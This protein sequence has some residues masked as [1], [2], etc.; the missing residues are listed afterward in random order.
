MLS[1]FDLN[2]RVA[3]GYTD[4]S[5]SFVKIAAD[6]LRTAVDAQYAN[7]R[8]TPDPLISINPS[9][10][11]GK[12]IGTEQFPELHEHTASV[13]SID[14]KPIR[15]HSHQE[16]ALAY[17]LR[18]ESYVV[19]TGT[20]SGK[21]L[22]FFV[23]I[24]DAA[25][26]A[27]KSG[28][29]NTKAIIIY[30]MNALAN[31]QLK[32]IEK[33]LS[34]SGLDRHPTVG[35]YTG[36][37]SVEEKQAIADSPPDILLTN[38]VMLELLLTRGDERDRKVIENCH[39]LEWLVLDEL[40]TY[41]GR[42]GADVAMLV[43]RL[44]EQLEDSRPMTCIGT[45][46]TMASGGDLD[47][48][49]TEIVS[50][51]ATKIF[52]TDVPPVRVIEEDLRRVTHVQWTPTSL[53]D[54]MRAC[55]FAVPDE[56]L[57]RNPLAAWVELEVGLQ[58]E[59]KRRRRAPRTVE[60]VV[61][62][63]ARDSGEP[64]DV[65]R[66]ALLELLTQATRSDRDRGG[67][68]DTAFLAFKLHRFLSGP[69]D[70][71]ATLGRPGE[72]RVVFDKQL[73]E[74]ETG[75]PLYQTRFCR[76][77]GQEY[78]P[79]RH[80]GGAF[81][82]RDIDDVPVDKDEDPTGFL[83]LDSAGLAFGGAVEDYPDSWLD[84]AADGEVTLRKNRKKRRPVRVSV[85]PDGTTGSADAVGAWFVPG[86]FAFCLGCLDTPAPQGRDRSRL[87]GL[88]AEGRSSATTV[89]TS[90][91]LLAMS[92][93]D[94][95][96]PER[97]RKLLAFTDN[98][99]D[100]ALQAGHFNDTMFVSR[101]RAGFLAAL[102]GA[103]DEGL[104]D[105]GLG[106]AVRRALGFVE[107]ERDRR[108]EWMAEPD[109]KGMAPRDAER[110]L[111]E[112]LGHRVWADQR[113][114][115]RFSFPNL[116]ELGLLRVEYPMVDECAADDEVWVDAPDRVRSAP[117]DRRARALDHV[118]TTMRQG[119][120]VA[121]ESLSMDRLFELAKTS[122][123]R[124]VPPW[125]FADQEDLRAAPYL[126]T[127]PVPKRRIRARDERLLLRGGAQ[128][129]LGKTL[130]ARGLWDEDVPRKDY[131]ELVGSLLEAA[132]IYGLVQRESTPFDFP[133][134]RL[135]A[136]AVRFHAGDDTITPARDNPY[137]RDLYLSLAEALEREG[138]VLDGLEAREH[139]AQVTPAMREHRERRF[140]Y[141]DADREMMAAAAHAGDD[142]ESFRRLPLMFCSP[143]M[144]LGVDI[145][146]LDV[147]Y[148]RNVP[149]TPA[150]YTQRA[151]RAGRAGQPAL[152]T[153]YCAAQSPHDQYYFRSR[154]Q[155]VAGEVRPPML[156][157]ANE[158]LVRSHLRAVWLAE[159]N[160]HLASDIAAVVDVALDGM[161]LRP[162]VS[163]P[164][165]EPSL[166]GRAERRMLAVLEQRF[167]GEDDT[168]RLVRLAREE[169]A[170]AF[171]NF[172]EA[173]RSWR[174]R[175]EAA[176]AQRD[177]A[178]EI[179][180]RPD[181]SQPEKKQA[182][183]AYFSANAQIDLLEGGRGGNTD[184]FTYR[185]LATEGFLPGYD[186]PRLPLTA[187]VP[188]GY[189]GNGRGGSYLSRSRFL[190]LAEFGPYSL[191]YHEGQA[192]RVVKAL[193]PPGTQEGD[194]LRTTTLLICAACG[195]SQK[196]VDNERCELCAAS[197]DAPIKIERAFRIENVETSPAERISA[198]D[199]ERQRQ[200]F[201][202]QTTFRWED[203]SVVEH[204]ETRA[205]GDTVATLA[206]SP[207]A[208]IVRIN[209]GLRRRRNPSVMGFGIGVRS[210]RWA[211]EPDDEDDAPANPLDEPVVRIVP[212][213]EDRKN[214]L[215][216]SLGDG[217]VLDESDVAT[218]QSAL[219]RGMERRFQLEE[220][221]IAIEP[222]PDRTERRN[223]LIYEASEGGAG[224]LRRLVGER[225]AL[226]ALAREALGAMHLSE[227]DGGWVDE[228]S[229]PCVRGCYRCLLS[230]Y[231]QPDH[232]LID[233]RSER[234]RDFLER[235]ARAEVVDT[236][237]VDTE[238]GGI[239][240]APKSEA[241]L[242]Q[243]SAT[244]VAATDDVNGDSEARTAWAAAARRWGLPAPDTRA[245][246]TAVGEALLGWKSLTFAITDDDAVLDALAAKGYEVVLVEREPPE[247]MPAS[248][249]T[250]FG[251]A[252]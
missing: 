152:I 18:R 95:G 60:E 207:A 19:T 219:A 54:S 7:G 176:R 31:S 155:M 48:R 30:P 157:L 237:S 247:T 64:E 102:R 65:C 167:A 73:V 178:A 36:Q 202:L 56:A 11:G 33:F 90:G 38:F 206:Y 197:L 86:R 113:R 147:V 51:V 200:G 32:E 138:R 181:V 188:G 80:D 170:D 174:D 149:P 25:L 186:F 120:A 217:P 84:A 243:T 135:T 107:A 145:S 6:D 70:L 198:N 236:G 233:R 129:R 131:A 126:L 82:F 194:G 94:S 221:E 76:A 10:E 160:I 172:E 164:L 109:S 40:H 115:W 108:V 251:D 245:P 137:Y 246:R 175:L 53:A 216:L 123:G 110:T 121:T 17:G 177:L 223:L 55:D 211:K 8:Y 209:K 81:A 12:T 52:A 153:T 156:D 191:V 98:R 190:A 47:G 119:L 125:S 132:R 187:F 50:G 199:E 173:F 3:R 21:S 154:D 111:T 118:L 63:L 234:A 104:G 105:E 215:L 230:Y 168:K 49:S 39:G 163:E 165:S 182:D 45:S 189:R 148:L 192:N 14:G 195:S 100:A 213:V 91:M 166:A 83:C 169:A 29:K 46:A 249:G 57:E 103:G 224:V 150:N 205:D 35:R 77:C 72:R 252:A 88:S 214:A 161:P 58:D 114:G 212:I 225:G 116:E 133:G 142:V 78:H 127:E 101:L 238:D 5:R 97:K 231:N 27:N 240:A 241:A 226:A 59:E 185:Y 159:A 71:Y 43:S 228:E 68:R 92:R 15:L 196:A 61:T 66:E 130:S 151:G 89:V 140:R 28:A 144:E 34:Q 117:A 128:S 106:Q 1:V 22:C 75:A 96:V 9:F 139:T 13:F 44:R 122:R 162:E 2:D 227:W 180:R 79:V 37:E 124:L 239:A 41:R 4:F 141:E 222:L 146:A 229:A 203:P 99:Q 171:E 143:T 67:K 23:P 235:L 193:L 208:T 85:G 232:P 112:V 242:H 184:F 69:D 134:W 218:V 179:R 201:E 93:P 244:D 158:D 62:A 136:G 250:P 42:Q 204:R 24:I 87:G 248:F 74:P 210:G 26:K 16:R 20:G 220:A 183:S